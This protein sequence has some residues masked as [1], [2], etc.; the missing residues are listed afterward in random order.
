MTLDAL[1]LTEDELDEVLISDGDT[2][3]TLSD[4]SRAHLAG[5][6]ACQARLEAFTTSLA[7]FNQA[8]MAWSEA[9]SN[10][11]TRDLSDVAARRSGWQVPNTLLATV[12]AALLAAAG[13][14]MTN[15]GPWQSF[16]GAASAASTAAESQPNGAW[17]PRAS[18]VAAG[19]FT[20]RDAR[21][22][23]GSAGNLSSGNIANDN[24]ANDNA[25]LNAID[26][27][28]S[29]PEPSP[30][31]LYRTSEGDAATHHTPENQG[32]ND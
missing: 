2:H 29:T 10:T 24:I 17:N 28:L 30:V 31:E 22:E 16:P 3:G 6:D 25:M 7:H 15:S 32:V 13:L 11:V 14:M 20:P 4:A 26:S 23:A 1:H 21:F 5:C 19:Q 27:V 9:R 18:A 8:S 12:S